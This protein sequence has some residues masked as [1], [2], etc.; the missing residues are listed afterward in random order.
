MH[1]NRRFDDNRKSNRL[2]QVL[3]I[4][5]LLVHIPILMHVAGIYH[6]EY[7]SYIEFTL[8]EISKPFSRSIPRPRNRVKP[9][10]VKEIKKLTLHQPRIPNIEVKPV[11]TTLPD[12]LMESI[13]LQEI[14]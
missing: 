5:S 3:I 6:S 2:L 9:P 10:E 13:S 4:I 11:D 14:A 8:D 1:N 7:L 12:S